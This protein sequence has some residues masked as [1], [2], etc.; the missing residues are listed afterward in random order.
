MELTSTK[1][2]CNLFLPGRK[3]NVTT[4]ILSLKSPFVIVHLNRTATKYKVKTIPLG[5]PVR[6]T[7]SYLPNDTMER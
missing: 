1:V 3:T 6:Q 5:L 4:A 2:L 7:L